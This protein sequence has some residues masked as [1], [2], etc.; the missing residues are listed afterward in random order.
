MLSIFAMMIGTLQLSRALADGHVPT[1]F[2][3]KASKRPAA[4]GRRA[5]ART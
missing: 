2:S 1:R 3:R 5:T 4:P